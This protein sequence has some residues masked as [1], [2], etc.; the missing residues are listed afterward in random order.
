M[1]AMNTPGTPGARAE[2]YRGARNALV[3]KYTLETL[4]EE[5]KREVD[6]QIV[7]LLI[8]FGLRASWARKYRSQLRETQYYGMA[9]IA[10]AFRCI[11]PALP[12]ILFRERWEHVKNPLV[13]L[14]NAQAEIENISNEILRKHRVL[15]VI[16]DKDKLAFKWEGVI[17]EDRRPGDIKR[18]LL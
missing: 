16:S 5:Q 6:E 2:K 3:A 13:A 12:G 11:P 9:A 14:T 7:D 1:K 8:Q 18:S 10:M 17:P 15:V 4:G